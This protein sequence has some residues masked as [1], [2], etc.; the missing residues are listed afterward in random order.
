[1]FGRKIH[2]VTLANIYKRNGIRN[3][4]PNFKWNL[5]KTTAEEHA[6][7][8]CTFLKTLIRLMREQW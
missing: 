3:L 1:M 4:K 6:T 8:K 2:R 5:G 7:N